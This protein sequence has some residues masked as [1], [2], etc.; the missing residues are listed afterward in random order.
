MSKITAAV[1]SGFKGTLAAATK[2]LTSHAQGGRGTVSL[3]PCADRHEASI[4]L[5]ADS[6]MCVFCMSYRYTDDN[7]TF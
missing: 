4:A 1:E 7:A 2:V 3:C 5:L 6:R